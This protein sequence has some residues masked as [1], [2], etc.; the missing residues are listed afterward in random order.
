MLVLQ[1]LWSDSDYM[2]LHLLVHYNKELGVKESR[3]WSS[4]VTRLL[5]EWRLYSDRS[6]ELEN[7]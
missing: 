3:D 5:P 4:F 1:S 7:R 2:N 6:E